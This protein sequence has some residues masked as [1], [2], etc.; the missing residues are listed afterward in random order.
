MILAREKVDNK[1][2]EGLYID[3][4]ILMTQ[5]YKVH[6]INSH[7]EYKTLVK[8]TLNKKNFTKFLE[9]NFHFFKTA[10]IQYQREL[11]EKIRNLENEV[12]NKERIILSKDEEIVN[13]KETMAESENN[14][15]KLGVDS[16]RIDLK[17]NK[18]SEK[19]VDEQFYDTRENLTEPL[20]T[21]KIKCFE[22][23]NEVFNDKIN[24]INGAREDSDSEID[25]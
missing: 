5:V 22:K 13:C 23:L 24:E 17:N 2:V 4:G 12:T 10:K 11:E 20:M 19:S 3:F 14:V 7:N 9:K 18:V 8:R 25:G 21:D 6:K 15:E 1:F 16:R